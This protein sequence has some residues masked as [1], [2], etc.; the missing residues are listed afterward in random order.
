MRRIKKIHTAEAMTPTYKK[1]VTQLVQ[2]Q[3]VREFMAAHIFSDAL[4]YVPTLRLQTLLAKQVIEELEHYEETIRLHSGLGGDLEAVV[5]ERVQKYGGVPYV[6]SWFELSV[7]QFLYDRAGKFHLAEYQHCSYVPYARIV[8]KILTEEAQH[9]SFAEQVMME[10]CQNPEYRRQA[11]G[12]FNEWLT[13]SLLSFGRPGTPGNRYAIT[14]GLKTRDSGE[15]MQD[16]LNDIKP[17][18]VKCGLIFPACLGVEIPASLNL[19]LPTDER[20]LSTS[21]FDRHPSVFSK[22]RKGFRPKAAGRGP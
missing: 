12:L 10:A 1:L 11:Q 17:G 15:V 9:E 21:A 18:M 8:R 7:C 3:G 5:Q 14:V 20:Y 13:F 6:K 22:N 16:Y 4:K 2:S 19:A